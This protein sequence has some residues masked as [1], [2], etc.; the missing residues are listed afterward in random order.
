MCPQ[1]KQVN[2]SVLSSVGILYR[3]Q[4]LPLCTSHDVTTAILIK[5]QSVVPTGSNSVQIRINAQGFST[6]G[7]A[8]FCNHLCVQPS[9]RPENF[10]SQ[11]REGTMTIVLLWILTVLNRDTSSMMWWYLECEKFTWNDDSLV[12]AEERG[13]RI[14]AFFWCGV[15]L[16]RFPSNG[17]WDRRLD[18][19]HSKDVG[20]FNS[21]ELEM[22]IS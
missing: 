17:M 3:F 7:C 18:S 19:P 15:L 10:S 9:W 4:C 14:P 20:W 5:K 13:R 11:W 21:G 2:W 12:C 8:H 16:S 6:T 22:T 1:K